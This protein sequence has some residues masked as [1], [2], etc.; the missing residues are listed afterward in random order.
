VG[1]VESGIKAVWISRG[2]QVP[3]DSLV[4]DHGVL[5]AT[6]LVA[7]AAHITHLAAGNLE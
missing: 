4:V 1:A 2:R 7:A 6:D 5:V 3:E